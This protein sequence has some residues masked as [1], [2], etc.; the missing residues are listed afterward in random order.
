MFAF[1][2]FLLFCVM[3]SL[4][5]QASQ[6]PNRIDRTIWTENEDGPPVQL[7]ELASNDEEAAFIVKVSPKLFSFLPSHSHAF[8]FFSSVAMLPVD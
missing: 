8:Y 2:T 5:P 3:P 6:D 1:C 7:T 4:F